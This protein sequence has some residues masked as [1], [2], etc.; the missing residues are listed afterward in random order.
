MVEGS[1]V[2]ERSIETSLVVR[3]ALAALAALA[4]D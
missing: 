2:V 1:K 4:V 3:A